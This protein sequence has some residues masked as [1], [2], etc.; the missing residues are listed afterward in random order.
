LI[1]GELSIEVL[2]SANVNNEKIRKAGFDFL[3]TDV[4]SALKDLAG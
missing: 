4:E 2:K 3:Y 1:L